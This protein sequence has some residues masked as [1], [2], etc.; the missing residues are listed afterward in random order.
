MSTPTK[1]H[2]LCYHQQNPSSCQQ[3]APSQ[4]AD[5][6]CDTPAL[7]GDEQEDNEGYLYED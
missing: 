4:S 6:Y 7:T 2:H 1:P 3:A 5:C